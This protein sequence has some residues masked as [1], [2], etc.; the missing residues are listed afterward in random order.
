VLGVS[1]EIFREW[2]NNRWR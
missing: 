2:T 1:L